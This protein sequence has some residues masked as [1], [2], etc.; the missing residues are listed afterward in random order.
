M[1]DGRQ[2]RGWMPGGGR[3]LGVAG[4]SPGWQLGRIGR[5]LQSRDSQGPLRCGRSIEGRYRVKGGAFVH[6]WRGWKY[7]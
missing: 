1:G 7:S 2:Y 4:R 3:G 6:R 5:G